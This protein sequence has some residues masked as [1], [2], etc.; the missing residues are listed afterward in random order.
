MIPPPTIEQKHAVSL[1]SLS[2]DLLPAMGLYAVTALLVQLPRTFQ[3]RL[4]L[5]PFT[6]MAAFRAGTHV[7]FAKGHVLEERLAYLNHG[8]GVRPSIFYFQFLISCF[9]LAG[10]GCGFHARQLLGLCAKTIQKA[11]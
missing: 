7:D 9:K 3:L 10:D 8:I 1:Q 5:L 4:A 6:L 11:T 2:Q